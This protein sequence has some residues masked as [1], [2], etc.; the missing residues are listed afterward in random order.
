MFGLKSGL[1]P[2]RRKTMTIQQASLMDT[3][4]SLTLSDIRDNII[5]VAESFLAQWRGDSQAAKASLVEMGVN[6]E[7]AGMLVLCKYSWSL[8]WRR[9]HALNVIG[10]RCALI[11]F[12]HSSA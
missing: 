9:C 10:S 5:D 1:M 11:C 12:A 3:V 7:L 4:R 2:P 6:G 8:S